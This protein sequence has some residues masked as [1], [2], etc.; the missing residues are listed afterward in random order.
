MFDEKSLDPQCKPGIKRN[1]GFI[2]MIESVAKPRKLPDGAEVASG[3]KN[4]EDVRVV[5]HEGT[6][7]PVK[8][9]VLRT[10]R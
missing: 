4:V 10:L 5:I 3:S 6:V 2:F 1:I 7:Q 8:W 9:S